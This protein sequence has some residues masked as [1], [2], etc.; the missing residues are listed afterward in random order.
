MD[1]FGYVILVAIMSV[2]LLFYLGFKVGAKRNEFKVPVRS[3]IM[4]MSTMLIFGEFP[5][6][7][8]PTCIPQIHR[9]GCSTATSALT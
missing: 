9:R 8:T 3:R 7:S 5:L 6:R 4:L 1:P 2:F